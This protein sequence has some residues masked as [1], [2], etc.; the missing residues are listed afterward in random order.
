MAPEVSIAIPTYNRRALLER[1]IASALA[2]THED[3][4][5]V[6][7][8]NASTDETHE[9]LNELAVAD[10]RLRVVRH[11]RNRGMV[12]NLNAAL[13]A[14]T[15]T[16]VMLLSDDD[17]LHPACVA[18]TLALLLDRPGAAA[19]LGHVAYVRDDGTRASVGQPV[20]LLGDDPAR[21]VRDYFAAV[22]AD[23]GN[24]WIYALARRSLLASLPPLRDVLAFDWLRVAELAFSGEIAMASETLI[25]RGL[26]GTSSTMARLV[27]DSGLPSLSAKLPHFVI[28]RE[29]LADVGWRS[30][31]YT[32]L[33]TR[34]RLA[35]A[36]T[37]G[38]GI[39]ARNAGHVLYH[40]APAALQRLRER[41]VRARS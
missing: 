7:C 27:G 8:D 26:G 25:H 30:P 39:P 19:A 4:E 13:G 20:A 5:V 29:V 21:R 35:L 28:A 15:G 3:V 40:L 33:G 36:A 18:T 6:V 32:P 9:L 17:W 14:A 23:H 41:Q 24:T 37:C 31:V 38:A 2:Q 22:T 11:A 10:H 34:R 16:Y 12:A 1:A